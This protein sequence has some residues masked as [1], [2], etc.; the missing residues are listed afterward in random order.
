MSSIEPLMSAKR[1]VTVLRSPSG[2]AASLLSVTRRVESGERGEVRAPALCSA[3]AVEHWEQNFAWGGFSAPHDPQRCANGAAHS[4]QNLAVSGFSTL[5]FEQRICSS[6]REFVPSQISR[7]VNRSASENRLIDNNAS[8]INLESS[9]E[10]S[11]A[12]RAPLPA[13]NRAPAQRKGRRAVSFFAAL[14]TDVC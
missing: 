12:A 14:A 7:C 1:A 6:P 4:I 11:V 2:T 8:V 3:I 13:R 9:I 5:Q 10:S